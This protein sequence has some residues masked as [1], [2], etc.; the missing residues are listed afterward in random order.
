MQQMPEPNE[1][2]GV[3]LPQN[4]TAAAS[5]VQAA[6]NTFTAGIGVAWTAPPSDALSPRLK[7]RQSGADAWI[8]V[9]AGAK[10]VSAQISGLTDGQA[11]DVSLAFETPGGVVGSP[12]IIEDVVAAAVNEA[13]IAPVD[14]TV[15][16]GGGGVALIS[17]TA[18]EFPALW[19]TQIFR[20]GVLIGEINAAQ[21][22]QL[23]LSDS[24]GAGTFDWTA[25]SV[26]V[27][28]KYS[29]DIGPI[30]AVIA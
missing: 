15:A 17:V 16:D 27:S 18:A 3:P 7:Y 2:S 21:G 11:Y 23:S 10:I 29:P 12:V 1:P 9:P 14:L 5:G 26:N 22:S 6:A 25:R 19:K 20:D 13:P 8:D 4:V 24:C 28:V 30:Q